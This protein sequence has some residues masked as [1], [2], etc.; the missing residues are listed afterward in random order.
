MANKQSA[1]QKLKAQNKILI[2]DI[3]SLLG[4]NGFTNKIMTEVTWREKIAFEKQAWTGRST[5]NKKN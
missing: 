5:L 2:N 3:Y 4:E 1:Y